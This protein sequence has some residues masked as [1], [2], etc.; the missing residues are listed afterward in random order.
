MLAVTSDGEAKDPAGTITCESCEPEKMP[1]PDGEML[2]TTNAGD[3]LVL[4]M[5]AVA[6]TT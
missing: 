2:H 6:C 4:L 3:G 1:G 5:S